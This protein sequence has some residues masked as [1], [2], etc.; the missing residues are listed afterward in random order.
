MRRAMRAM[1]VSWE[2]RRA[3]SRARHAWTRAV[4]EACHVRGHAGAR[5][6]RGAAAPAAMKCT[7]RPR[8]YTSL[9]VVAHAPRSSSGAAHASVPRTDACASD[10]LV[11]CP[12]SLLLC[13]VGCWSSDV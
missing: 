5:P 1:R 2:G 11:A 10:M 12:K 3:G 13:M 4:H 7:T 6:G 8:L 9:L